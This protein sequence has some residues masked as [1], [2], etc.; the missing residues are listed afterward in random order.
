[1]QHFQYRLNIGVAD[2]IKQML[3]AC[4]CVCV[5]VGVCVCVCDDDIKNMKTT[6]E[7]YRR[8]NSNPMCNPQVQAATCD[9]PGLLCGKKRFTRQ[10]L[11]LWG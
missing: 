1:M 8:T 11:H 9:R 5:C 3:C 10:H 4:N 6:H 7:V 2:F